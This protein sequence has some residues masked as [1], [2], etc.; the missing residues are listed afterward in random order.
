MET[1]EAAHAHPEAPRDRRQPAQAGRLGR[2]RRA[3]ATRRR[4][5]SRARPGS[6]R[7]CGRSSRSGSPISSGSLENRLHPRRLQPDVVRLGGRPGGRVRRRER[8]GGSRAPAD[9]RSS[10]LGIDE[11][12][13]LRSARTR[14]ARRRASRRPSARSPSPRASPGRTARPALGWQ[15][16]SAAATQRGDLRRAGPGRRGGRPAGPRGRRGAGRRRRTRACRGRAA[17]RRARA[18][19]TFLRSSRV[20]TQTNAGP[21]PSQPSSL[22]RGAGSAPRKRSRSTPESTT[23]VLPRASGTLRLE[24]ARAGSRRRRPRAAARRTTARVAAATPG[25]EPT[26][27]TSRPCAVTTSGARVASPAIRPVGTRK[28]A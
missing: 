24:L 16:T 4:S 9:D 6:R 5:R 22:A 10:S 7:A 2:R 23:S 20:P 12:A 26:L 25:I 27:R 14:A 28:C 11:D 19:M 8:G 21:S 18:R 1:Y 17:R 13:G 15:T 3:R